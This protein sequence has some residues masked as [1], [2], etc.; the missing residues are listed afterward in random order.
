MNCNI[1]FCVVLFG[2]FSFGE[3]ESEK[4]L[5][6]IYRMF[7]TQNDLEIM[8][9]VVLLQ[10][11][12]CENDDTICKTILSELLS[13]PME[14]P[15]CLVFLDSNN[16]AKAEEMIQT[17]VSSLIVMTNFAEFSLMK[18]IF[19]LV[20]SKDLSKNAWL[21]THMIESKLNNSDM[22]D[23]S[24]NLFKNQHSIRHDSQVY[25]LFNRGYVFNLFEIYR[26]CH[27]KAILEIIPL[28]T[29]FHQ[30][31]NNEFIWRRRSNLKGCPLKIAY[32]NVETFF[33]INNNLDEQALFKDNT[34]LPS[35]EVGG[36]TFY[37][38]YTQLLKMIVKNFNMSVTWVHGKNNVI[39]VRDEIT[40]SWTGIIGMLNKSQADVSAFPVSVRP[41]R[42]TAISFSSSF[43]TYEYRLFMKKPG[44]S[45][46]WTT[47]LDVFPST[48]WLSIAISFICF[49]L[50]VAFFLIVHH[51][52]T[53]QLRLSQGNYKLRSVG[54]GLSAA[55][56]SFSMQ[57][58]DIAEDVSYVSPNSMRIL[59]FTV[60]TCGMLNHLAYD[61][62]LLSLLMVKKFYLPIENLEDVLSN[63][64]YQLLVRR[65]T[66]DESFFVES[67]DITS[68]KIWEKT[69]KED[70]KITSYSAGEE[71][72]MK[73]SNKVLFGESPTVQFSYDGFPCEIVSAPSVYGRHSGAYAFTTESPYLRL[74]GYY[75]SQVKQSGLLPKYTKPDNSLCS[76][77][78]GYS[79]LSYSNIFS[80]FVVCGIGLALALLYS[81]FEFISYSSQRN[82]EK[83]LRIQSKLTKW[84][85]ELDTFEHKLNHMIV[86]LNNLRHD[87][88]N[89]SLDASD[90]CNM[91]TR[92]R[93]ISAKIND[94]NYGINLVIKDGYLN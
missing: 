64:E 50:F 94:L 51:K 63:S 13:E 52:I 83:Q 9:V 36:K 66:A 42:S 2:S 67:R 91:E 5:K 37:G 92:I 8:R 43:E 38:F 58:I 60:C 90:A 85:N 15:F 48:Y 3:M 14:V 68:Q 53:H 10:N 93:H 22:I 89:V 45:S 11:H 80:A 57:D 25:M 70:N 44:F 75:I 21:F 40:G 24:R 16:I 7:H 20:S 61:A 54:T 86:S 18:Q 46:S 74:F 30:Y 77:D 31:S 29:S 56:L 12:E 41:I 35:I 72:L 71:Y 62:G 78:E 4:I 32:V 23:I 81:I 59:F 28:S 33:E 27:D 79:P 19:R 82:D 55:F 84:Y 39:G 87:I 88:R 17:S 76:S 47:F 73:D 26:I 65:G 1:I 6:D 69:L 34:D 49:S